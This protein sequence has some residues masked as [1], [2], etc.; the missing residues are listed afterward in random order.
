[1]SETPVP[2]NQPPRDSDDPA[3]RL[4]RAGSIVNRNMLWAAGGGLIPVPVAD[5]IA[6]TA[7]QMKMLKELSDL[8]GVK[9]TEGLAKKSV[10]AL[11]SGIGGAGLGGVVGF[12]L[13]K[14]LPGLGTL[15]GVATIPAFASGF[16]Y[17]TGKVFVMHFESGGTFLDFDPAAVRE[18]FQREFELGKARAAEARRVEAPKKG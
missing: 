7:V 15:F 10:G 6:I 2:D 9:F 17:A 13:A 5:F 16:T 4:V 12:S 8:Y 14:L 18:H 11:L 1:M 3:T